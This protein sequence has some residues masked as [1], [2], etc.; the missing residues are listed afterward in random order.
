MKQF[1]WIF[2]LAA[3]LVISLIH[4]SASTG[5]LPANE[6]PADTNTPFADVT[7]VSFSGS[8]GRYTFRVEISSPDSGCDQYAD[9]WEIVTEDGQLIYRRILLHSHVDEQ[10]FTRGGG[11]VDIS[12]ETS[13]WIR[14]HM[15]NSGY[16][17]QVFFGSINS[18][19]EAMD[20]PDDFAMQLENEDPLPG[21]CAF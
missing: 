8:E 1:K 3:I 5:P 16:G 14:A 11:P 4:C 10:P 18:G 20:H 21:D 6:L 7:D 9:W 15:S 17:G 2:Y 19:F 12:D 13:V